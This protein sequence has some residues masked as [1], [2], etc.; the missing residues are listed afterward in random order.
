[1]ILGAARWV[2]VASSPTDLHERQL[3]APVE[4]TEVVVAFVAD[5]T[6]ARRTIS[7]SA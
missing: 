5:P 1:M 2:R 6:I 7:D 3:R 4:A